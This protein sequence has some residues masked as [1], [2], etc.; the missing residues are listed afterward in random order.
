MCQA[1]KIDNTHKS[2]ITTK[3]R[4]FTIIGCTKLIPNLL[5]FVLQSFHTCLLILAQQR[6]SLIY[7]INLFILAFSHIFHKLTL[8]MFFKT[9]ERITD[10]VKNIIKQQFKN[11]LK[12]NIK[13]SDLVEKIQRNRLLIERVGGR[14]QHNIYMYN[15]LDIFRLHS[16]NF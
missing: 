13:R 1:V 10:C 9:V 7:L 12:C 14:A 11:V 15:V 3:T 5:N 6:M 2:T 16:L 4:Y 8:H